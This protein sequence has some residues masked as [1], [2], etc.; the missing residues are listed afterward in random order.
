MF[1]IFHKNLF[2]LIATEN[3]TFVDF[4][5]PVTVIYD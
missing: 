5:S 4:D 3:G 1:Y 2:C